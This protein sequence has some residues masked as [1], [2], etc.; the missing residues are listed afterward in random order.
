[1]VAEAPAVRLFG[2]TLQKPPRSEGPSATPS[3]ASGDSSGGAATGGQKRGAAAVDSPKPGAADTKRLRLEAPGHSPTKDRASGCVGYGTAW[4]PPHPAKALPGELPPLAESLAVARTAGDAPK[5]RGSPGSTCGRSSLNSGSST[6]SVSADVTASAPP[7]ALHRVASLPR[8]VAT[9]ATAAPTPVTAAPA[10]PHPAMAAAAAG[11]TLRLSAAT[12]FAPYAAP[13][14]AHH[15]VPQPVAALH[16]Q[17]QAAAAA[18]G[19]NPFAGDAGSPFAQ[20]AP[21]VVH[22]VA[23]RPA[24][25]PSSKS[26]SLDSHAS[27]DMLPPAGLEGASQVSARSSRPYPLHYR[28][29]HD[30]VGDAIEDHQACQAKQPW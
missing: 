6:F 3:G 25:R 24:R 20:P 12:A 15:P 23:V 10:A 17:L 1:M 11:N 26:A 14:A 7:A 30:K 8:P 19:G 22:P 13:A 16:Q 28:L 18:A 9:H 27:S 4:L 5:Q 21:P 2:V 29:P